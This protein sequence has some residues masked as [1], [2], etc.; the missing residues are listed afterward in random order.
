MLTLT[1]AATGLAAAVTRNVV[2]GR[3]EERMA[4]ERIAKAELLRQAS[5]PGVPAEGE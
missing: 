3:F 5:P 2:V 1:L 4:E